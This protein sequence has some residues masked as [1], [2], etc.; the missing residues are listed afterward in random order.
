MQLITVRECAARWGVTEGQARHILAPVDARDRDDA[1]G[2]KLYDEDE[3]EAARAA[4]PGRGHRADLNAPALAPEEFRRLVDNDAIPVAHRALWGLL[5]EGGLRVGEALALAVGDVDPE[6]HRITA[7]APATATSVADDRVIP[8]SDATAALARAALGDRTE[9]PFL[10]RAVSRETAARTT[11]ALAGTS[12]HAFRSGGRN[13]RGGAAR[14][15]R[16]TYEA[17]GV[18][19]AVG[20]P[21]QSPCQCGHDAH[22]YWGKEMCTG[23]ADPALLVDV[24]IVSPMSG[25]VEDR[26]LR[27]FCRGCYDAL[28]SAA[29]KGK[30]WRG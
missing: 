24:S 8:L 16:I 19:P 14:P 9:G 23:D 22:M 25:E 5:W 6:A 2:A 30:G 20:K 11:Q 17:F 27:P 13:A 10:G 4:G 1:T 15:P 29:R 12:V 3:A 26:R 18:D 7:T 21:G 28:P